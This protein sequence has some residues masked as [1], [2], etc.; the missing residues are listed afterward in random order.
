MLD[1]VRDLADLPWEM[2]G[3]HVDSD[4]EELLFRGIVERG[5][6]SVGE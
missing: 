2:A 1:S 4:E 5:L 6:K 3:P